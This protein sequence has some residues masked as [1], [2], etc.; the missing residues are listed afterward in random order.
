MVVLAPFFAQAQISGPTSVCAG[1]TISLTDANSSIFSSWQSSDVGVASVDVSGNVSG[2]SAGTAVISYG[3]LVGISTVWDVTTVTVYAVPDPGYMYYSTSAVCQGS[4]ITLNESVSNGFWSSGNTSVATVDGSGDVTGVGGGTTTIYYTVTNGACSANAGTTV[5]VN[6]L[7]VPGIISGNTAICYGYSSSLTDPAY[8]GVWSSTNTSVAWVDGSGNVFSVSTGNTTIS[9]TVTNSCGTLAT[10]AYVVVSPQP[11]SVNLSAGFVCAQ[12]MINATDGVSGGTWTSANTGIATI[13]PSTGIVSGVNNGTTFNYT[14]ITYTMPGG[15]Y[16]TAPVL[17]DPLPYAGIIT[18]STNTNRGNF[19]SL[20]DNSGNYTGTWSSCNNLIASVDASGNVYGIADG[21]TVISYKVTGNCGSAYTTVQA[22]VGN[23]TTATNIST[24]AGNHVNGYTG[25]GGKATAADMG[26][27]FGVVADGNGNVYV[28]D[29]FNNVIRKID[30]SGTITT[31]AGIAGGGGYNGDNIAAS[32]ALLSGPMGLTLDGIGNLYVAD[33]LNERVRVI[34][35]NTGII[36]SIAGNGLHGG[37]N[38]AD[39]GYGGPATAA[40]LDYPVSVALDCSGNIYISDQGSE[41]VRKIDPSGNIWNFAGNHAGGYN[42]DNIQATAAQL[43]QPSGITADCNGNVYIADAWNNRIRM[44]NASGIISTIA[45]TGTAGY[46]GD[47]NPA[48]SAELWIPMG[49]TL[50]ACGD[51]Y[52]SDW[53]N[54]VVRFL[55]PSGSTWYISTFAG[56][57]ANDW[58]GYDGDGGPTDSAYLYLPS[59]VA[60]DGFGNVY[61]ADYGNNVVRAIGNSLPAERTFAN[62]TTQNMTVCENETAAPINNQMTIPD[63]TSGSTETWTVS[64]APAHGTLSGF[65]TTATSREGV[66]TPSGLTYTPAAGYTGMDAFT[67]VMNDGATA[68]S[69]T[70]NVKVTPMPNAGTITGGSSIT[71]GNE[72]T[73]ADATGDPDGV[74]SSSNDLVA[75]VDAKG[76]VTGNGNGI[77]TIYYTVTNTCG[78]NSATARVVIDN[79]STQESKAVLFPNP[80]NGTFQCAFTSVND[81][82]LELTVTDVT[83]KIVY[84]QAITA[85]AGANVA[86]INLPGN[87]QRPS[88]FTVSLGNKNV[89]YPAVKITVTE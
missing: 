21:N 75:S 5:Y 1:S 84:T 60:I 74:W 28:S 15:C 79:M 9:Y 44:V 27:S 49:V 78:S 32:A 22:S 66:T 55:T 24:F 53:Q 62:G 36:T 89:K 80:N 47:G 88:L 18:G 69:T 76:N 29:Y 23:C 42:G 26:S 54:N 7:P 8:G 83:G 40:A 30:H 85:T 81:C 37:W 45:G 52:V 71:S 65:S 46:S 72:I 41:T 33:K 61:I 17:V 16:T 70:V 35:L 38:H 50:D 58:H 56:M 67:I 68:A 20:T 48:G 59:S 63:A 11:G 25:D 64:I 10:S 31:I 6:P 34:N 77:A 3:Y 82:Q 39:F 4:V 2:I 19:I 12:S 86:S 13:D 57:N 73:L 51:I 14:T 43:N 87:I